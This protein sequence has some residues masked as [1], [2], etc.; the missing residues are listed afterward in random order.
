ML[1]LWRCHATRCP[2][3]LY[4]DT[5]DPYHYLRRVREEDH[6]L[7]ILGGADHKSGQFPEGGDWAT[8]E[9]WG[10]SFQPTWG[11]IRYR[12][13]G[14]VMETMDGLAFIGADPGGSPI[15]TSSP[16]IRVWT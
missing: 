11:P 14:Q 13:S 5:A 6:D 7:I 12:W 2:W 15:S 10:Q 8:L 16:A 9:R 3:G 4:W 1:W